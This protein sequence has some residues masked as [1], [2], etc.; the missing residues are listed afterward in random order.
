MR[1][2]TKTR[3]ATIKQIVPEVSQV[4]KVPVP[5]II[6]VKHEPI[7]TSKR[8]RSPARTRIPVLNKRAPSPTP[9]PTPTPV[10]VPTP[11]PKINKRAPSP[12]PRLNKRAPSPTPVPALNRRAPSPTPVPALNKRA[13][14]RTR[15]ITPSRRDD[16][17]SH[18]SVLKRSDTPPRMLRK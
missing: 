14:S 17:K 8:G 1:G 9:T 6:T 15:S 3:N 2:R 10:P 7:S 18:A 5:E 12:T 4:S 11:T 16:G 13:P